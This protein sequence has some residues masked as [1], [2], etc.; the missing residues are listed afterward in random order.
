MRPK[1]KSKPATTHIAGGISAVA[2]GPIVL[3]VGDDGC[4]VEGKLESKCEHMWETLAMRSPHQSPSA[5]YQM[6]TKVTTKADM[7]R[8]EWNA[9]K[10]LARI[11]PAQEHLLYPFAACEA[12]LEAHANVA[13]T[14]KL[15]KLGSHV[16]MLQMNKR[17]ISL[18]DMA[19][20]HHRI[21]IAQAETIKEDVIKAVSILHGNGLVHGDLH[22]GNVVIEA[23]P[24]GVD[25]RAFLIDFGYLKPIDMQS[26]V[27]DTKDLVDRI[28]L[29]S[30]SAITEGGRF[31]A[32]SPLGNILKNHSYMKMAQV[33]VRFVPSGMQRSM[34]PSPHSPSTTAAANHMQVVTDQR[35]TAR[36]SASPSS[37]SSHKPKA[38]RLMF[39]FDSPP[40]KAR[41]FDDD[42]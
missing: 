31:Y 2:A 39:S 23:D 12:S 37:A 20:R 10:Q 22:H 6:I 17:G 7:F 24:N 27:D 29:D 18:K 34:Y 35:T 15:P 9:A 8:K 32:F 33:D 42:D 30:L 21:T 28:L 19:Q 16:Y 5:R 25:A 1:N 36:P 4:V 26:E 14:C 38:R 41:L 3:G 40:P 11:D 13:A